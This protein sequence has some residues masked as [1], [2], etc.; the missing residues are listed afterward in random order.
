MNDWF[1]FVSKQENQFS[2]FLQGEHVILRELPRLFTIEP[3]QMINTNI[4]GKY[5]LSISQAH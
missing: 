5:N 1:T 2:F 4:K 3:T